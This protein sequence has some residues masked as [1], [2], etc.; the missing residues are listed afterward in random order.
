ME[1]QEIF[2]EKKIDGGMTAPSNH[3]RVIEFEKYLDLLNGFNN[4]D[5]DY[6]M[7]GSLFVDIDTS[8]TNIKEGLMKTGKF[9]LNPYDGRKQGKF[10]LTHSE[11]SAQVMVKYEGAFHEKEGTWRNPEPSGGTINIHSGDYSKH[12]CREY[13]S[14][15][16]KI[17][18]DILEFGKLERV[19]LRGFWEL[20]VTREGEK[21]YEDV[22]AQY[23]P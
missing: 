23:D 18:T 17:L 13:I 1:K 11:T 2:N 16:K 9:K 12:L 7:R 8:P 10:Q 6:C 20:P 5:L 14:I 19:M 22:L 3:D 15:P 21:Y 4:T